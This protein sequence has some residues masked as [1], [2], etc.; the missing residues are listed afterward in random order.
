MVECLTDTDRLLAGP[1]V[2]RRRIGAIL[3]ERGLISEAQLGRALREQRVTGQKLGEILVASFGVSRLDLASALEQQQTGGAIGGVSPSA[4]GLPPAAEQIDSGSVSM[5]RLTLDLQDALAPLREVQALGASLLRRTD[6][7][8]SRLGAIETL[9]AGLT[10]A[11]DQLRVTAASKLANPTAETT[12]AHP[13]VVHEATAAITTTNDLL[14][15][16]AQGPRTVTEL[17]ESLGSLDE[18]LLRRAVTSGLIKAKATTLDNGP[19]RSNG[20]YYLTPAGAS[21]IGEDP[22]QHP[23]PCRS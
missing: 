1:S 7:I 14:K 17:R 3:V 21:Q 5:S 6:R 10:A 15:Q 9:L 8:E 4:T 19:V 23:W 2:C 12:L 11:I 13:P 20:E 16:L 18:K 22:D